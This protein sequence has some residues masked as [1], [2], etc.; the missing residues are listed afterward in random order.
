MA[1]SSE[2]H[3]VYVV[4]DE[5]VITATLTAILNQAGFEAEGFTTAREVMEAAQQRRPQALISDVI[6]PDINGIELGIHFKERYPDTRV[7]L[8]SGQS[9]TLALLDLAESRGFHFEVLAKPVHPTQ[10]IETLKSSAA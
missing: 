1:E 5:K 4:D 2:T 7:I 9:G 10:I 8:F 6:M 3:I